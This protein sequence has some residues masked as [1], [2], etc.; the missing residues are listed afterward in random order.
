LSGKQREK[1]RLH[2]NKQ[3]SIASSQAK[4]T[5]NALSHLTR[6]TLVE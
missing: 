1:T 4:F 6:V 2:N 3:F 5:H